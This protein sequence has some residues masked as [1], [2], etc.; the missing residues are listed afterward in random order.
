MTP[1]RSAAIVE[2]HG[3]VAAVPVLLRRLVELLSTDSFA[4]VVAPPFR[5]SRSSITK[6]G[7]IERYVELAAR[8]AGADGAVVVLLDA[9]D[10]CPAR[11]GPEL[12]GR[13]RAAR[14]GYSISVVLAER[15]YE[16]W[17]LAAA[18]SLDGCP[19]FDPDLT[20]PDDA[21]RLRDAKGW[22]SRN[23]TDGLSYSPTAD[24]AALTALVDL[25]AAR[26]PSASFDKLCRDI[27][28]LIS[29]RST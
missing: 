13:A 3:E 18:D 28:R 10:D 9:D 26:Q 22:L 15:E 20:A 12:L 16:S 19:G 7:Q 21:E 23:R 4:D 6:P 14:P 1:V 27:E 5:V 2:G 29:P 11:L 17:F 8:S 25:A 24:Q